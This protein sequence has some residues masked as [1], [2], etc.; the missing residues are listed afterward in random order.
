MNFLI[1]PC[2]TVK[3]H[4]ETDDDTDEDVM[5][6]GKRT[7]TRESFTSRAPWSYALIAHR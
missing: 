6:R 1:Q 5:W 2:Q 7:M 4:E 3:R